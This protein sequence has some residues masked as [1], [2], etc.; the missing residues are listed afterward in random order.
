MGKDG[1]EK[2]NIRDIIFIAC[3]IV[4]LVLPLVTVNLKDETISES[5]NRILASKPHIRTEDGS[6]NTEYIR[7]LETWV[8]DNIGFRSAMV[9]AN[10]R[11]LYH[12][13]GVLSEE[14]D[15][16]LGPDGEFNYATE[17][18]IQDYCHN[19]RYSEEYLNEFA[20]SFQ[21]I[22][23]SLEKDGARVY[24]FQCWDK[25]SI[26]PESFPASVISHGDISKTD[27]IVKAL[28]EGTDISVISPKDD[29]IRAK[30]SYPT[31]GKFSDPTHWTNRG[32]YIGYLDLMEAINSESDIKYRVLREEDYDLTPRDFGY[33]VFGGIH[34]EDYLESF[35]ILEP[36]AYLTN[37]KLTAYSDDVRHRFYTNDAVD[38]DTRLLIV[39]DSYFAFYLLDDLA[40]SFHETVLIWG[41]YLG[42]L[43]KITD[44]YDADIIVVEAAERV[45]R[46]EGIIKAS[47]RF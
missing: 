23:D 41:D 16:Y 1:T 30:E 2:K 25:H 33:T 10:A 26:Y 40:E 43:K 12:V 15:M 3:F 44:A 42:D 19:N 35:Y 29:L 45:D 38:N 5:E 24:Y 32:A 37:E 11:L 13:F 18:M 27:E 8:N 7:D 36:K 39:G 9:M 14:S 28:E 46:T 21:R 20:S 17:A 6:I 47:S 4:M 31:Y 22:N 34:E